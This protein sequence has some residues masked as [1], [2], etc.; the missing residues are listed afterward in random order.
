M[1]MKWKRN[2]TKRSEA[3]RTTVRLVCKSSKTWKFIHLYID[4]LRAQILSTNEQIES[5]TFHV[6]VHMVERMPLLLL[7]P[8]KCAVLQL[9]VFV[10]QN[11]YAAIH[12]MFV[13]S[14]S[15]YFS[16]YVC[17][18]LLHSACAYMFNV[19]VCL[20]H[21]IAVVCKTTDSAIV[22]VCCDFPSSTWKFILCIH[23]FSKN[24]PPHR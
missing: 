24:P 5:C 3:K 7:F 15:L 14:L 16:L 22:V 23:E 2:G 4:W 8:L 21:L 1:R 12:V 10:C 17:D 19:H 11:P 6:C 20:L 9:N 18:S 13:A